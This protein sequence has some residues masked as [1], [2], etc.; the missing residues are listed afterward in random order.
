MLIFKDAFLGVRLLLLQ[1]FA[2]DWVTSI[3][4][5]LSLDGL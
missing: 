1:A 3:L 4:D 5:E 2:G